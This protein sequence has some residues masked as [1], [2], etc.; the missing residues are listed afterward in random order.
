MKRLIGREFADKEVQRDAKLVYVEI[1]NN[2]GTVSRP[3]CRFLCVPLHPCSL[4]VCSHHSAPCLSVCLS[5]LTILCLSA[6]PPL[7]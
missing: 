2:A 4:S 3:V 5:A 6:P 1:V 7:L